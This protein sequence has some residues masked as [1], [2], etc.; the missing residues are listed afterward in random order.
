MMRKS[1]ESTEAD[2]LSK[3]GSVSL[4]IHTSFGEKQE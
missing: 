1:L 4:L 2:I 3:D